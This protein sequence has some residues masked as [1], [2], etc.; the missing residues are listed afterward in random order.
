MILKF[1]ERKIPPLLL[2]LIF[3]TVMWWHS[4]NYSSFLFEGKL[5]FI[6]SILAFSL[7]GAIVIYAVGL[8]K[9]MTLLL[10]PQILVK[11][12]L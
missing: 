11:A 4:R 12:V 10:T 9:K 7:G 5:S 2:M 8:F 1:M 6:L 3:G